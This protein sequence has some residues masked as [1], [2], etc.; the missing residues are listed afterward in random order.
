M[1]NPQPLVKSC[2]ARSRL[3]IT[4]T[5]PWWQTEVNQLKQGQ[6]DWTETAMRAWEHPAFARGE[7]PLLSLIPV[8]EEQ[9]NFILMRAQSNLGGNYVRTMYAHCF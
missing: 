6:S 5:L 9:S 1:F 4:T 2:Q 3:L 8:N 7:K